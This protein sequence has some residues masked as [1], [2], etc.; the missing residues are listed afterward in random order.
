[1][2]LTAASW[3]TDNDGKLNI[4]N[5]TMS[6]NVTTSSSLKFVNVWAMN[7]NYGSPTENRQIAGA[8][9]VGS[10]GPGNNITWNVNDVVYGTGNVSLNYV[11]AADAI[12][13][14]VKKVV[15]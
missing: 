12:N 15:I 4:I 3:D 5:F 8:G 13:D 6:E 9:I 11:A 7:V 1:M 2:F 14:T 10:S